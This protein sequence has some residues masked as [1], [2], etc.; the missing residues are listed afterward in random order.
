M[1]NPQFQQGNQARLDVTIEELNHIQEGLTAARI[2]WLIMADEAKDRHQKLSHEYA[3][4]K[5]ATLYDVIVKVEKAI[6]RYR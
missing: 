6:E 4:K 3:S 1:T 5:A 2:D